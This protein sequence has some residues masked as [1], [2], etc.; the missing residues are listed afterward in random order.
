MY[1]SSSSG[2]SLLVL[3]LGL[4]REKSLYGDGVADGYVDGVVDAEGGVQVAFG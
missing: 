2:A 3:G 1:G 4:T